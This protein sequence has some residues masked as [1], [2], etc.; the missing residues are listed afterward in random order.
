[1]PCATNAVVHVWFAVAHGWVVVAVSRVQ[2]GLETVHF[3]RRWVLKVLGRANS[4][5]VRK[6]LWTC[7]E[8]GLDY[9]REDWGR[10]HR[11]TEDPAFLGVNPIGLVPAAIDG[12][13]RLRESNTIVR[14]LASKFG[15]ES[16][17]PTDLA[18]RADCEAW[19][20]W[21]NYETSISLRGA[22]LAGV[23]KEPRWTN[24]WFITTG[25][26]LITGEIG[27]LDQHFAHT[28]PWVC[29]DD[30]T[31]GDIPIGLVVNR[32]FHLDFEK[33]DYRHVAA[34]YERLS[35]RAA[36]LKHGRNGMP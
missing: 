22:F 18:K 25:R 5:N 1:M 9:V 36:Y 27:Q 33:P 30:F 13:V 23:M 35:A 6:V 26:E 29:G 3:G 15:P 31:V 12:D 2:R 14:Y 24:D 34:Y 28:G 8:L 17:Y 20:D 7:E 4:I 21:A 16:F 32:W 11:P 19:M 10:G